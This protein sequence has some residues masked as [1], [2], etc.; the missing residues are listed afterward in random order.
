[1]TVANTSGTFA[2]YIVSSSSHKIR[3]VDDSGLIRT[4][5]GN[6]SAAFGGDGGFANAST[7]AFNQPRGMLYYNGD[8]FVSDNVNKR[9][10][11]ISSNG[12]VSTVWGNGSAAI[13]P[14][15]VSIAG[16]TM[17]IADRGGHLI[18]SLGKSSTANFVRCSLKEDDALRPFVC[19]DSQTWLRGTWE[20][21]A[22]FT[23]EPE[24]PDP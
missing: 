15:E 8:L 9:I 23:P 5:A 7:V 1:M 12:M 6:G 10:R 24:A 16:N 11:K 14:Y 4:F 20:P 13:S 2:L 19:R 22:P 17:Y 18:R 3:V 21:W